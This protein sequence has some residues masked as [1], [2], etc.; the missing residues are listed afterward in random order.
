[1]TSTY[2]RRDLIRLAGLGAGAVGLGGLAACAPSAPGE[3]RPAASGTPGGG[4]PT[5]FSFGSW[6]L[7]EEAAAPVVQAQLDAYATDHDIAIKGVTYPFNEYLNQLI[8]QIRGGQFSGAAQLDVAWLGVVAPLGA[9]RDVGAMVADAGYTETAVR[10]GQIDGAQWG[11]PWT[12][13]A[14]G[15]VANTELLGRIGATTAPE[16]LEDFEALLT[17]LKAL[18]DGIVPYAAMT[19]PAQM[20]DIL[21]WM[22]TFGSPL[23]DGDTVTIGDEPSVEAVAWFKRLYDAGLI[24]PDVDRFDARALFGQGKIGLYDDAVKGTAATIADSPDPELAAKLDGIAR[25]VL[26]AGDTPRSLLWGHVIVVVDGDGAD[27]AADYARWVTS[28]EETVVTYFEDILA[29]PALESVIDAPE[30]SGHA[31]TAAFNERVTPHATASPFWRFPQ[32]AQMETAVAE[33]VQA[34]LVG[35]A[36]PAEAMRAAGQAVQSLVE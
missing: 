8:L 7:S 25:P 6:S 16:T 21:T 30:I 10:A 14:I 32:Y 36:T 26:A 1:M 34:V 19:K 13:G 33:Q 18:G 4:D 12:I 11:V 2:T 17:E 20:K 27:T 35:N 3:S 31:L 5:D 24:A 22:E 23:V 28:D 9:L 15:M 29:P